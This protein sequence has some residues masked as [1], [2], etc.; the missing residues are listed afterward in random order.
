MRV[1]SV[2]VYKLCNWPNR[3]LFSPLIRTPGSESSIHVSVVLAD[4]PVAITI[5]NLLRQGCGQ[6]EYRSPRQK[7][8][9]LPLL[10]LFLEVEPY[11]YG[12]QARVSI[13]VVVAAAAADLALFRVLVP[14]PPLIDFS[15]AIAAGS[16]AATVSLS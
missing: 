2:L 9:P 7:L 1:N 8:L 6:E 13:V 5:K 11:A 14:S 15:S 12:H 16:A 3:L 4:R 10:V